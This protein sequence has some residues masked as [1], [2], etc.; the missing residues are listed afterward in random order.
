MPEWTAAPPGRRS[1]P[2]STGRRKESGTRWRKLPPGRQAV[3]V[4]AVLRHD[5]RLADLAGGN[6]VSAATT[7]IRRW[8]A[9]TGWSP[10]HVRQIPPPCCPK[11]SG[12]GAGRRRQ[13]TRVRG[14]RP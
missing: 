2:S 4:L 10:E 14:P 1:P 7:T 3:I 6:D 13:A 9:T 11:R 8:L 12:R 5:Q